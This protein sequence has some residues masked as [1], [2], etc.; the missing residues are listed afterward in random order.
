MVLIREYF[1]DPDDAKWQNCL[2]HLLLWQ[3]LK[4]AVLTQNKNT[5]K[6]KF[7]SIRN[8]RSERGGQEDEV[9]HLRSVGGSLCGRLTCNEYTLLVWPCSVWRQVSVSGSH[10]FTMKS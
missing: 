8:I 1:Q 4:R 7:G 10:T 2:F 6:H 5:C 9:P 3:Q